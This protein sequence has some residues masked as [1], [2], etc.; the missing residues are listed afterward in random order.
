MLARFVSWRKGTHYQ[1]IVQLF[2][3]FSCRALCATTFVRN[4]KLKHFFNE[5]LN[6]LRNLMASAPIELTL[7]RQD[8]KYNKLLLARGSQSKKHP[9]CGCRLFELFE[10]F[11]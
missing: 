9:L 3:L 11:F 5:Q 10:L 8:A 6:S 2:R 7:S 4:N 1:V